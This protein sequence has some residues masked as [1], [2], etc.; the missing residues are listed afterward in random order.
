LNVSILIRQQAS[1]EELHCVQVVNPGEITGLAFDAASNHL[2]MCNR[3][4]VIQLF[5]IDGQMTPRVIFSVTVSDFLPKAI[6]FG[7]MSGDAR[8]V[9]TFGL[10]D[11]QM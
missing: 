1:F 2:I 7:Q 8:D 11:G 10:H 4:S 5:M 6:A 9:L 3:N